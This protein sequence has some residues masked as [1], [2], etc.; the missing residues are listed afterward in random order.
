MHTLNDMTTSESD[1]RG[2]EER[3]LSIQRR[4]ER[5]TAGGGEGKRGISRCWIE[6]GKEGRVRR[7][8]ERERRSLVVMKN[9]E[10]GADKLYNE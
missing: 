9:D 8:R 1:K 2:V 5:A 7:V 10:Q 6:E 3:P 4:V